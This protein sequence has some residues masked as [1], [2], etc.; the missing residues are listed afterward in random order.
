VFI[1]LRILAI[2]LVVFGLPRI[3]KQFGEEPQLGA[4][5]A[6]APAPGAAPKPA[7]PSLGQSRAPVRERIVWRITSTLALGDVRSW[8]WL[9]SGDLHL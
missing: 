3:A 9:Q 5:P 1:V 2:L 4:A 6:P 7:T 8:V